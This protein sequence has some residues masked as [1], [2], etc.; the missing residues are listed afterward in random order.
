MGTSLTDI[1]REA[2]QRTMRRIADLYGMPDEVAKIFH[3]VERE[4]KLEFASQRLTISPPRVDPAQKAAAVTRDYLAD[5][6]VEEVASR[7]GISR[8]SVYNYLKR[9]D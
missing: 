1:V 3:L 4:I 9:R 5:L 2:L 8:R 6:P 7:H